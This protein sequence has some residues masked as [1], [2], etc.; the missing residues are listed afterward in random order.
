MNF[1]FQLTAYSE[2]LDQTALVK[3]KNHVTYL[4]YTCT[5]TEGVRKLFIIFLILHEFSCGNV[6]IPCFYSLL[7]AYCFMLVLYFPTQPRVI[8]FFA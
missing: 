4:D 7:Q 8:S 1:V 2:D 5:Q 6:Q 3:A